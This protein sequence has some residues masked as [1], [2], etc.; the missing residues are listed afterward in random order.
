MPIHS[1]GHEIA[2]LLSDSSLIVLN[3][4]AQTRIPFNA[5]GQPSSPDITVATE[6]IAIEID[7]MI[8]ENRISDHLPI[9]IQLA[10]ET[11]AT[12][13]RNPRKKMFN[14]RKADWPRFTEKLELL[15]EEKKPSKTVERGEKVLRKLVAEAC[16]GTVPTGRHH[17]ST[18]LVPSELRKLMKERDNA[19]DNTTASALNKKIQDTTQEFRRKRWMDFVEEN[20]KL[21]TGKL[22]QALAK[23]SGKKSEQKNT[24]IIFN[25]K[26][27]ANQK[28]IANKLNGFLA[29]SCTVKRTKDGRQ[30][31]RKRSKLVS[32]NSV[33]I[34]P[35][36]VTDGIQQMSNSRAIALDGMASVHLKH[37]GKRAQE[38]LRRLLELSVNSGRIPAIWKQAK[39]CPL[40]KPNKP[41]SDPGSY[42]PVSILSP[43]ARLVER[44]ILPEIQEATN[45]PASQHGFR[46]NHSTITA[47]TTLTEK[48]INGFNQRR[49]P[50]RTVAVAL[51]LKRAF[52]TV[53]LDKLNKLIL[54]SK[55]KPELK[56]WLTTYLKGREQ[57]TEFR[58]IMSRS[59][60]LRSGVPQGSVLSPTLFAWYTQDIPVPQKDV[61]LVIYADDITVFSQSRDYKA[62]CSRINDY[63][64]S[65]APYLEEKQ[66]LVSIDKC[67]A[68]LFSTW[69]R[70]WKEQL[71]IHMCGAEI[72]TV[73]SI[74]LL[75]ITLDHSLTFAEHTKNSI[76]KAT[77]KNNALKAITHPQNGLKKKDVIT[78]YKALTKTSLNYGAAVWTPNVSKTNFAKLEVKQ[79]QGLRIATGCVMKTPIDHLREETKCVPLEVNCKLI[80]SQFATAC[81]KAMHPCHSTVFERHP[82]EREVKQSL[83]GFLNKELEDLDLPDSIS[84]KELHKVYTERA[85]GK[86]NDNKIL[87]RRPPL[88]PDE[89]AEKEKTL[90]RKE[91]VLLCQLRSGYCSKLNGFKASLN[92]TIPDRCRKCCKETETCEHFMSCQIGLPIEHLWTDPKEVARR[93]QNI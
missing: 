82:E 34:H 26:P 21:S 30:N 1:R 62:A 57:R 4:G 3:S 78:V 76:A 72:P 45:L 50:L 5:D 13:H 87:K 63:L 42:R 8:L 25:G 19:L 43:I 33:H 55:L 59:I 61:E 41:E 37:F 22:W 85:I 52:D 56:R 7:W 49:P 86:Y 60:T 36:E 44:I 31:E 67:A 71:G 77:K 14:L 28:E 6:D 74:K 46:K 91:E 65:L 23:I 83:R 73:D 18:P 16:K 92:N 88:S 70:E 10:N 75:G 39:V 58:G 20:A 11:Q 51:D 24:S 35:Q 2:E 32:N 17:Q 27:V 69:N 29:K 47:V 48:V 54:D 84:R 9:I 66:L 80:A 93:C 53:H 68:M 90:S 15:L 89:V 40:Q 79:N 81:R 64:A 38:H 12:D